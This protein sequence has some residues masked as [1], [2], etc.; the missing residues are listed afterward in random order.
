MITTATKS[1]SERLRKDAAVWHANSETGDMLRE[2]ADAL[3]AKD[4]EIKRLRRELVDLRVI[5]DG[6]ADDIE[7]LQATIERHYKVRP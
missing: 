1:L 7:L 2:A 3:D 4:A 5:A 6:A